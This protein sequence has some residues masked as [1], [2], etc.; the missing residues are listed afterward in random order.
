MTVRIPD[1]SEIHARIEEHLAARPGNALVVAAWGGYL[2]GLLD[3]GLIDPQ[4]HSR[5][6]DVLPPD[7]GREELVELL[8][9]PDYK[10]RQA[11]M[12]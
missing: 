1:E 12:A 3:W 7:V 6:V 9:G 8:V 5:L 11:A 2:N 4:T 10:E